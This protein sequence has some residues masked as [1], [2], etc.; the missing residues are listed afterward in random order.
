[1]LA[2]KNRLTGDNDFARVKT[3]GKLYQSRSFGVAVLKRGEDG[4]SRFGFVVSTKVTKSAV[5][6]NRIKRALREAVRYEISYLKQGY[7]VVFLAKKS[8][9][10]Q[11]TESLMRETK[12]FLKEIDLVK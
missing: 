7:D 6:R 8:A 1:M 4:P 2:S 12:G 9:L 5:Q 3:E 10:R 11:L